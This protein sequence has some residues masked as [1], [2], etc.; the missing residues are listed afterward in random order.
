[1]YI[2]SYKP[3][4]LYKWIIVVH[5]NIYRFTPILYFTHALILY[6]HF[7]CFIFSLHKNGFIIF[8]IITNIYIKGKE[9]IIHSLKR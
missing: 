9:N 2:F 7:L 4:F 6:V 1:M 8:N 3:F 5:E